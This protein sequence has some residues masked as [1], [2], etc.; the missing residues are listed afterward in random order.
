VISRATQ[1]RAAVVTTAIIQIIAAVRES[2]RRRALEG[3]LREE[4]AEVQRQALADLESVD[5]HGR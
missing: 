3:Y 2:E 5:A 4:F 1:D